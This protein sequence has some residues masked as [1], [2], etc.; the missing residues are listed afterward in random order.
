MGARA[1]LKFADGPVF[2]QGPA[3]R[4]LEV[5]ELAV[6]RRLAPVLVRMLNGLDTRARA[7]EYIII[8]KRRK[9]SK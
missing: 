1:H 8:R 6:V 2:G 3:V 4:G 7:L 9:L 5:A